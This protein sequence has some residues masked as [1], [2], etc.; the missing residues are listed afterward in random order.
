V[1]RLLVLAVLQRWCDPDGA[2][3]KFLEIGKLR[4][5]TLKGSTLKGASDAV[6][7]WLTRRGRGVVEPIDHQEVDPLVPP[8]FR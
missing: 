1:V 3:A 7:R 4:A 6:P 5:N 2:D 8:I